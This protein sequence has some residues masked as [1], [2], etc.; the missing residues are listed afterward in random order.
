MYPMTICISRFSLG[1]PEI[2]WQFAPTIK[3][4]HLPIKGHLTKASAEAVFKHVL[5]VKTIE[6]TW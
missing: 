2:Y 6:Q 1:P 4:S 5:P 3:G